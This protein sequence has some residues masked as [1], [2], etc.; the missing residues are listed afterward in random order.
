MYTSSR[1]RLTGW[2][3]VAWLTRNR[4]GRR[5]LCG[6]DTSCLDGVRTAN[7]FLSL[8]SF[9][10]IDIGIESMYFDHMLVAAL[11]SASLCKGHS[12]LLREVWPWSTVSLEQNLF[13]ST[14]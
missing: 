1:V 9:L 4:G 13:I 3:V 10:V 5:P 14:R 6:H 11:Q 7:C 2:W 8:S 12:Y